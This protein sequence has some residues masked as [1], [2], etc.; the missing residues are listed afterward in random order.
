MAV[1]TVAMKDWKLVDRMAVP[2]AVKWVLKMVGLKVAKREDQSVVSMVDW[3]D[4]KLVDL[5]VVKTD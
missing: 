5:T 4:D 2:L 1:Q 3:S